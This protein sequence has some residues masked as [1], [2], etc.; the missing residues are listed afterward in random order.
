LLERWLAEA[1]YGI[2]VAAD[3]A[4]LGAAPLL[5]I[6][7]IPDPRAGGKRI[8]ELQASYPAPILALSTRF[9]R[10]LGGSIEAAHRLDVRKVLPKPFTREELLDAVKEAVDNRDQ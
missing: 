6:A 4:P 5:V 1:G 7:D 2:S 8:A 10:G 9:R 3:H